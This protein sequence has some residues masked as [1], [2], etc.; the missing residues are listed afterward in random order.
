MPDRSHTHSKSHAVMPSVVEAVEGRVLFAVGDELLSIRA[1][2]SEALRETNT[3][4]L[5][6]VSRSDAT[7]AVTIPLAVGGTA[8]NITDYGRIGNRL[9]MA[10]GVD[11]VLLRVRPTAAAG[12]ASSFVFVALGEVAG[13]QFENQAATLAI[14]ENTSSPAP[15]F[16]TLSYD[17]SRLTANNASGTMGRFT[18]RRT[19]DLSQALTLPIT[20][21]GTGLNGVDFGRIGNSITFAPNQDTVSVNVRAAAPNY[22]DNRL[23]SLA[24]APVPGLVS[25]GS[26]R[27]VTLT[28]L[29]AGGGVGGVPQIPGGGGG[30]P[31]APPPAFPTPTPTVPTTPTP[32]T[33]T[34]P[35]P[36]NI[37][38]PGGN[39]TVPGTPTGGT[40]TPPGTVPGTPP[41]GTPTTPGIPTG[42]TPVPGTPGI[43][44]GG[45]PTPTTPGTPT[46]GTPTPTTPGTPTGGTP[47][48]TTPGI[49]T[50]GTPTPTTPMPTTP[51]PGTPTGGTPTGGTPTGGTPTDGTPTDGTP[52]E[53]MFAAR[54]V[55]QTIFDS[56]NDA[57]T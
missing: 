7:E 13:Y 46:G 2:N 50:G 23:V 39:P 42:G 26:F 9:T 41:G 40:P 6:R 17:T 38:L 35:T 21:G 52:T 47:T 30:L 10:P 32:T 29:N 19:G 25:T 49:P 37:P 3:P 27:N 55:S 51:A 56:L 16:N 4:G 36:P 28:G 1:V 5:I 43:P 18:L 24:V 11:S 33:P 14:R 20:V 48:P 31:T 22:A 8:T 12:Q 53:A 57:N 45:T 15:T 54:R 34:T 44:T